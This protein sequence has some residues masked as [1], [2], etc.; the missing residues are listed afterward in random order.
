[1]ES[2][3]I[4]ST[5]LTSECYNVTGET[6]DEYDPRAIN[7]SELEGRRDIAA[8][9][10]PPNRV[11][12]SLEIRKVNIGATKDQ[13]FASIRDYWDETTMDKCHIPS[14]HPTGVE[15]VTIL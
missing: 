5:A 13:K 10:I 14:P 7:I 3:Q 9:E 4:P 15:D 8:P 12:H 1:M 6:N 11:K 2:Q